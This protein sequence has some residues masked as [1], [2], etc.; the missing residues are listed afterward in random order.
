MQQI[1]ILIAI[2]V[3]AVTAINCPPNSH[4]ETC[5]SPCRQRCNEPPPQICTLNCYVGCVCDSGYVLDNNDN[6][7]KPEDCPV[8]RFRRI[9]RCGP[10]EEF[11]FCGTACEP[12]CENPGPRPCTRQCVQGCQCRNGFY[13]NSRNQCVPLNK[14]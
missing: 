2:T 8:P 3:A 13:R 4:F 9:P 11:K 14:C 7:V 6:C 5:A 10:N 1:L 12:T